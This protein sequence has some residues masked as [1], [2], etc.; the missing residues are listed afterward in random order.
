MSERV[1]Q[2][3]V[4]VVPAPWRLRGEGYLF[5]YHFARDWL[6]DHGAIPP[7]LVSRFDG[8]LGALMLVDYQSG[9]AEPYRELLFIPGKFRWGRLTRHCISEIVVSTEQSVQSGRTN[10]AIPKRLAQFEWEES[11]PR[12]TKIEVSEQGQ[13]RFSAK[14]RHHAIPMPMHT[15]LLPMPLAQPN[16]AELLLTAYSGRGVAYPARIESLTIHG[17]QLPPLQQLKPI[18]GFKV[19]PFRLRFPVAGRQRL[20]EPSPALWARY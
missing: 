19:K 7:Q 6:L 9:T 13:T 10:W 4:P 14:L 18:V 2:A 5:L 8:G 15:A 16:G 11:G 17:N 20:E 12:S 1:H 3:T